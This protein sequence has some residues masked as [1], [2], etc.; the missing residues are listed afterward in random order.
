MGSSIKPITGA[1]IF[2]EMLHRL[3]V[4]AVFGYNGAAVVAIFDA[5]YQSPYFTFVLPRHEQGAG[6]M[7]QGYARA[8]QRPGVVLVTSGPGTSNMVTPVLDAAMDSTPLVV[9]CGQVSQQD[10]GTNAFQEIPTEQIMRPCAKAGFT[11][12]SVEALPFIMVEA[13]RTAGRGRPGPVVVVLPRDISTASLDRSEMHRAMM[14]LPLPLPG[15]PSVWGEAPGTLRMT[16][17]QVA[18]IAEMISQSERPVI[19]AGQGVVLSPRGAEMVNE[20]AQT[21]TIPVTTTLPALGCFNEEDPKSLGMVG[22]YGSAAANLAIQEA[23]LLL[24]LGARLDDRV[25]RT[26]KAFALKARNSLLAERVGV[27]QIN[28]HEP[29]LN[30][31]IPAGEA[32]A[33]DVGDAISRVLPQVYRR[34]SR[35]GWMGQQSTWKG[36]YPFKYEQEDGGEQIMPQAVLEELDR[37]LQG[38]SRPV[39]ITTGVGRHQMWA[40]QFLRWTRQRK[41]ITSGSLGTM[42]FGLPAAIGAKVAR[43]DALVIDLDGDAS[44]CMTMEELLSAS[45]AGVDVKVVIFNNQEQGM[46]TEWQSTNCDKRYSHSHQSNPRFDALAEAMGVQARIC[47]SIIGGNAELYRELLQSSFRRF[48]SPPVDESYGM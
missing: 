13:F 10:L 14:S 8:A 33:C 17:E 11:V 39:I 3:A 42:G 21:A 22:Q 30:H 36:L 4:K 45:Q 6:H 20:L 15:E 19:L 26:P 35:P 34:S 16:D 18:T 29:H 9:F 38:Q 47:S 23:D 1:E 25:V 41:I 24:V 2:H 43:P 44:F 5:I 12:T 40:T 7:A 46:V 31:V 37:Q 48:D 28:I 32:V 27:V